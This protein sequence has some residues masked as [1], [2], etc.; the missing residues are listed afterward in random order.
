VIDKL[1]LTTGEE[2]VNSAIPDTAE[3]YLQ[4][5]QLRQRKV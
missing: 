3:D 4:R 1:G 5:E 2:D